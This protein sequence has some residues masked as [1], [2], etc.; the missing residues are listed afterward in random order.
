MASPTN[1]IDNEIEINGTATSKQPY[2]EIT[3]DTT[4]AEKN[5]ATA[6]PDDKQVVG[7]A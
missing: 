6:T 5:E 4:V 7:V 1:D 3:G 2:N